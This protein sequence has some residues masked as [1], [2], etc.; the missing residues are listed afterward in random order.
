MII[1]K[2][3]EIHIECFRSNE[4]GTFMSKSV[5]QEGGAYF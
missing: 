4:L 1:I 2:K 3:T 5:I